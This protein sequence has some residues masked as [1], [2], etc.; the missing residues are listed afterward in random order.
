LPRGKEI[1]QATDV[2]LAA[3]TQ[4]HCARA[5]ADHTGDGW[6]VLDLGLAARVRFEAHLISKKE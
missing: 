5:G 1:K 2:E 4:D 3:Y 6:G